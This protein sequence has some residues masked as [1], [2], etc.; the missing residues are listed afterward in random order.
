MSDIGYNDNVVVGDRT[1]HIQTATNKSKGVVRCEVFEKGRLI[2]TREMKYERRKKA[3][4]EAS[5]DHVH[6]FVKDVHVSTVDE[7][8]FLF[9]VAQRINKA[10]STSS[11]IKLGLLFLKHNLIADAIKAF[12]KVLNI[13]PTSNRAMILLASTYIKLNRNDAAIEL[14]ERVVKSGYSYADVYNK[15][16]LA[17]LNKKHFAK[18]LNY[19]Q[20]ALRINPS[21]SEAQYN[22]AITYLQSVLNDPDSSYLPPPSIRLERARQLLQKA[23][24][25]NKNFTEKIQK[26]IEQLLDRK[27]LAQAIQILYNQR[28]RLFPMDTTSLISTSF[29]LKF[30]YDGVRLTE[31]EIRQYEQEL[32]EAIEYNPEYADLWNSLGIVHLIQCRNL[33]MQALNEFDRALEI[34]PSYEKALKNKKLVENDGKEFLILLRA[35]LK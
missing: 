3:K 10:P 26:E 6:A 32:K 7:L 29:Y 19:F 1:F 15:L 25:Q 23:G 18:A 21:Y 9:K 22:A 16:G 11:L 31:K 33:F 8:K 14:L 13:E 5:E 20:E 30:M 12:K 4:P 35:I 27:E 28:D 17:Y 2:T 24:M 34:N